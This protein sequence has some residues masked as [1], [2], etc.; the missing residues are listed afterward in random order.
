M[1]RAT[2]PYCQNPHCPA[3]GDNEYLC[4]SCGQTFRPGYVTVKEAA[5]GTVAGVGV[6]NHYGEFRVDRLEPGGK[7]EVSIEAP[8]YEH[9]VAQ[10][11]L[12]VSR[13]LGLILLG[14]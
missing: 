3:I 14:G 13:N 5:T 7:Y 11:E 9:Y 6:T 4:A 12:E 2:C 8:G 10:V 1:T